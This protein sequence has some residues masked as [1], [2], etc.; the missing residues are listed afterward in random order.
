MAKEANPIH[1]DNVRTIGSRRIPEEV[2][3]PVSPSQWLIQ[4]ANAD[5]IATIEAAVSTG[6][7]VVV[8]LRSPDD[9]RAAG[10]DLLRHLLGGHDQRPI[11]Q[12]SGVHPVAGVVEALGYSSVLMTLQPNEGVPIVYQRLAV[13]EV[14]VGRIRSEHVGALIAERW[15]DSADRWP[16]GREVLSIPSAYLS[17]AFYQASSLSD[18]LGIL[19]AIAAAEDADE[20][21]SLIEE[22]AK[23]EPKER[24][25]PKNSWDVA[26][27]KSA[28]ATKKAV[29]DKQ[30]KAIASI[31]VDH[32]TSPLVADLAGYGPAAHWAEDLATDIAAYF[33][34]EIPFSDVD[35]GCLLVGPPGTGKTMFAKAVAATCGLPV[36]ATSYA[37]WQSAGTGHLGDVIR[38][39]RA[40]FGAAEI[41][42]PCILFIDEIDTVR[43][44]GAG[45]G[46]SNGWWTAITTCL[47]ECLDGLG[48][49]DGIVTIGAC[50]HAENLDPA[51]V[52]S[53]RLDRRF[54]I[55]LPDESGLA[56]IFR[57]H[58]PDIDDETIAP[59]ATSLAGTISGADVARIAREARREAR[60]RHGEVTGDDLLGIAL[61]AD[62][63][64]P[65]MRRLVAV[66]EAGHAVAMMIA[67][68]IPVSLSIVRN[69]QMHGGVRG[70]TSL[71]MGRIR[72]IEA[73]IVS[74]LAGRAAEEVI[75]GTASGGS[76]GSEASDLGRATSLLAQA[77]G[78]LGL[79][80][81]LS[82]GKVAGEVV[83]ARIRRLYAEAVLLV[84]RH[85]RQVIA[86]AEL[87]LEKRVLGQKALAAFAREHELGDVR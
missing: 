12:R 3:H 17:T 59:I 13:A 37:T 73:E 28:A 60:R 51:L 57:H 82:V 4:R 7:H 10:S 40:T 29:D 30:K 56:R 50:N 23:A 1:G 36:I 71:G 47:L 21:E 81:R 55:A 26:R 31:P 75:L 79:G 25:K 84:V 61:P 83:E 39:I 77:D 69:G 18:A 62:D 58:L 24:D 68:K 66:H 64:T 9:W 45:G 15:P 76:G 14:D 63:R 70:D 65:E 53:G 41:H 78:G 8:L 6:R 35:R 42:A 27:E 72:D 38:S 34:D 5:A 74:T 33:N 87:A 22:V 43:G 86:L 11:H 32:P 2:D 16:S 19:D 46:D 49:I 80:T 67:G 85:R 44:R 52:R 20:E 54:E 48:R